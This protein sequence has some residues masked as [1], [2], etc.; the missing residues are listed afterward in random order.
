MTQVGRGHVNARR[1]VSGWAFGGHV[2]AT[3]TLLALS[4]HGGASRKLGTRAGNGRSG[5]GQ[6]KAQCSQPIVA[7]FPERPFCGSKGNRPGQPNCTKP[8]RVCA[9]PRAHDV[10]TAWLDSA[11]AQRWNP[12]DTKKP[13]GRPGRATNFRLA[14]DSKLNARPGKAVTSDQIVT[15]EA[16]ENAATFQPAPGSCSTPA[17][18]SQA[19]I[20]LRNS[21][22][23][24]SHHTAS[25]LATPIATRSSTVRSRELSAGAIGSS[26]QRHAFNWNALSRDPSPTGKTCT[27]RRVSSGLGSPRL[28]QSRPCWSGGW[29]LEAASRDRRGGQRAYAHTR[30]GQEHAHGQ[31]QGGR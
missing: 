19:R 5:N 17:Q 29:G 1:R 20:L 27:P 28:C 8:G 18:S 25:S 21:L 22:P 7:Q 16:M 23:I 6:S 24:V 4:L 12:A 31:D 11:P 10:G 9:D 14:A 30:T 2:S 13:F 15:H 26:I 3:S